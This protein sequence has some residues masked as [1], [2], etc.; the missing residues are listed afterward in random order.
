MGRRLGRTGIEL[1]PI[2]L[3][4]W[5]FSGGQ[6]LGGFFWD[7]VPN[8][9][10]HAIV[11]ASLEGGIDWFDT[12]ELYGGGESE[13]VLLAQLEEVERDPL[14]RLR[15]D[16]GEPAELVDQVLDRSGVDRH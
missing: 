16:A 9:D 2:G 7:P 15:P 1:S 4:C 13:R 3:G 11:R 6:G 12:A 5:Q 14:R 10:A 8:A